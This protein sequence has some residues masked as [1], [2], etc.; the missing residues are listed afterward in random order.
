MDEKYNSWI[1]D[2]ASS[3]IFKRENLI[4][5]SLFL[6]KDELLGIRYWKSIEL[7]RSVLVFIWSRILL[8]RPTTY[9]DIEELGKNIHRY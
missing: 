5:T 3:L 7:Q 9:E 8:A 6:V 1:D 4:L 2:I